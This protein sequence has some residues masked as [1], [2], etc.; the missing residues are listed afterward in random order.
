MAGTG[1]IRGRV[2]AVDGRVLPGAIVHLASDGDDNFEEQ[3]P[4][5]VTDADGRYEFQRLGTRDAA[6]S[7]QAA[8]QFHFCVA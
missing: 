8:V 3:V 4:A 1:V 6:E 2:V 7:H 5:A